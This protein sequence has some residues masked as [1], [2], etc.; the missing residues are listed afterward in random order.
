[1]TNTYEATVRLPSGGYEKATVDATSWNH[2]RQ[3]L[4]M[5]H[6]AGRVQ[7]LHQR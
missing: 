2:A 1:M 3:L 5:L 4:E 6:G 7:N